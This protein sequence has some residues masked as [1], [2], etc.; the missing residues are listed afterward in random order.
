MVH[1]AMRACPSAGS[2]YSQSF[3]RW[4]WPEIFNPKLSEGECAERNW[5]WNRERSPPASEIVVPCSSIG[6]E[7]MM[8]IT[9][10]EALG[11]YRAAPGPSDTSMRSM[12]RSVVGNRE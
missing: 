11:P 6:E 2:S 12:S 5:P 1:P 4:Y 9:P 3:P 7:V 8:C 10:F